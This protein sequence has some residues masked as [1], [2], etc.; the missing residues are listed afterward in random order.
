MTDTQIMLDQAISDYLLWMISKGYA[1]STCIHYEQVL[2]HFLLFVS[3]KA[4][5]WDAAFTF[6]TLKKFQKESGLTHAWTAPRGLCRYLF[7]HN[8][9]KRPIEKPI[10][11]LPEIH[12]QY[13]AYYAKARQVH[14][15]HILRTR[16][17]MA[18]FNHYLKS[19]KIKLA[20]IKIEQIDAF[21]AERNAKFT[22]V[23]RQNE[24]SNLRGFLR[25]LYQE[26][27]ILHK[28]LSPALSR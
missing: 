15:C 22:P 19:R 24:R 18:A 11:K 27:K 8:R 4:I 20:A 16:N 17:T 9:I 7:N 5:P 23:T 14:H 25:Y 28:D 2:K 10:Q 6:D 26:R 1:D 12:E 21:L 3:Q 13:L